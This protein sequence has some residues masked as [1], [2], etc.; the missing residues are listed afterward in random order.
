MLRREAERLA[1][2]IAHPLPGGDGVA[3]QRL[4]Q[5]GEGQAA[6]H[7]GVE[8]AARGPDGTQ[9]AGCCGLGGRHDGGGDRPD[10]H[11]HIARQVEPVGLGGK[12]EGEHHAYSVP[13]CWFFSATVIMVVAAAL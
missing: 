1:G 9:P 3:G 7:V 4:D 6:G 2:G 11:A 5:E 8:V 13:A 12:I 10:F